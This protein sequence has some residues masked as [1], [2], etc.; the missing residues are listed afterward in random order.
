MNEI[1]SKAPWH[2]WAVGIVSLLWSLVGVND[3][4][5]TQLGNLSYLE[6]AAQQMNVPVEEMMAYFQSFPAWM[7]AAWAFGVWGALAGSIVLLFRSGHAVVVFAVS[8]AGLAATTAYQVIAGTPDWA[9][10][11]INTVISIVIW[12]IATFLL[13]YSV[14]MKNKGVLR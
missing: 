14:S 11:G 9:T 1:A 10:G 5:Q 8:L 12:S 13:T 2:L 7:D 3:Y 4:T 6:G